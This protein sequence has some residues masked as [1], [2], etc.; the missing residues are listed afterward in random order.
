MQYLCRGNLSNQALNCCML[1]KIRTKLERW[2][3]KINPP[4]ITH[5]GK[6]CPIFVMISVNSKP[7]GFRLIMIYLLITII[8][9]FQKK[10]RGLIMKGRV[11]FVL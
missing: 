6:I 8:G 4:E 3:C 2:K 9:I 1:E 7:D 5:G 11:V 10:I